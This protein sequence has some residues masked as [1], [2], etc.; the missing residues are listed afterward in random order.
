[1]NT[2]LL[3]S[4]VTVLAPE[5][6]NE[7]LLDP[8][9]DGS[10][11]GVM[12]MDTNGA[13]LFEQNADLRMVPASNQKIFSTLYALEELGPSY[14]PQTRIW[15]LSDGNLYVDAPGDP[16]LTYADLLNARGGLNLSENAPRTVF[17]REAYSVGVPASWENDDLPYS[18]APQITAFSYDKAAFR[19]SASRERLFPSFLAGRVDFAYEWNPEPPEV[20]FDPVGRIA[21]VGGDLGEAPVDFGTFAQP[22]PSGLAALAV[23][24]PASAFAPAADPLPEAAPSQTIV[25]DPVAELVKECLEPSDNFIAEH[26]VLMSASHSGKLDDNDQFDAAG[27]MDEHLSTQ[28]GLQPGDFRPFD[29]SGMSRHNLVTPRAVAETL[30]WASVQPYADLYRDALAAPGEGTLRS[31]LAGVP[32]EGKTGTL[33]STVAL[34]GYVGEDV[35]V[36]F[37]VNNSVASASQVRRVQD[38]FIRAVY[39]QISG[40]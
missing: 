24:G 32:F 33:N 3:M 31:R 39:S 1:M 28:V 27:A 8:A 4:L 36:V 13:V 22:D 7:V 18:Y 6:M 21:L 19:L 25:G 30:Q 38:E 20:N 29:G 26:L 34:S 10:L 5:P 11:V 23:G 15:K 2:L 14:R 40:N 9:L 37:L 16:S 35:I 17:T 12:V